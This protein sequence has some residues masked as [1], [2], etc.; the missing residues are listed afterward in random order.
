MSHPPA[1]QPPSESPRGIPL[2]GDVIG[3]KYRVERVIGMGGMGCVV[4]ARHLELD[5]RV[6]IKMLLPHL[7]A[8]GE[9]AARFIREAKAAI[10]IK[11]EHVVRVLDVGKDRV[12]AAR[13]S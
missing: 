3:G 11:N 2:T 8:T 12:P 1:D 9:P 5:E 7:G 6:A 13:T 10:R 4:A